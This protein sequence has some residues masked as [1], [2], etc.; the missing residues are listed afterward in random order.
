MNYIWSFLILLGIGYGIITGNVSAISSA[1]LEGASE[2]I[3]LCITM[4]GIIALWSGI[5]EIGEKAG[6]IETISKILKPLFRFLFPRIPETHPAFRYIATNFTANVLGLG[7]AATPAG[8]KAMEELE[9][10]EDERRKSANPTSFSGKASIQPQPQGT[11][12]NEM[13][14]FLIL[15]IS[16]LQLLPMTMIAYRSQ[17]GSLEPTAIIGPSIAATAISTL[18]AIIFCKLTSYMTG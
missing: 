13:C 15:N 8:L 9:N 17:Y 12:N 10:L 5:M 1:V 2:G 16:S 6:L 18:T 14:T 3:T 7:W 11:A 4:L